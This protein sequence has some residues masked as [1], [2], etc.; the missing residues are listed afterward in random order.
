MRGLCSAVFASFFAR[1]SKPWRASGCLSS[2]DI[3]LLVLSSCRCHRTCSNPAACRLLPSGAHSVPLMA[4][5]A[6]LESA[7]PFLTVSGTRLSHELLS[8]FALG[9]TIPIKSGLARLRGAT[10]LLRTPHSVTVAACPLWLRARVVMTLAVIVEGT[11]GQCER[12]P[13]WSLQC[14]R[15]VAPGEEPQMVGLSLAPHVT[16]CTRFS[17]VPG[18]PPDSAT[19]KSCRA[20]RPQSCTSAGR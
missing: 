10:T 18:E 17:P 6:L 8:S 5:A 14:L 1:C 11:R 2:N 13:Q 20:Q 12:A 3:C 7:S 19:P 4:R 9:Q 16:D 15:R